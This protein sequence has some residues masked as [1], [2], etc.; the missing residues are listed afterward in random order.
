MS[1][2]ETPSEIP[3]IRIAGIRL[4]SLYY[5][6][7]APE[8]ARDSESRIPLEGSITFSFSAKRKTSFKLKVRQEIKSEGISFRVTHA[9]RFAFQDP[10]PRD[11]FKNDAFQTHVINTILPF[12]SELFS[13]LT[14]K[15]FAAPLITPGRLEVAGEEER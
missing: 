12:S 3:H 9:V 10:M 2:R 15:S 5:R 13:T 4:L 1:S 7:T 14:G 6:A 11:I 8:L